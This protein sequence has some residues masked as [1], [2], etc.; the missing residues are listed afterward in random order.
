MGIK[1]ND[2]NIIYLHEDSNNLY[3]Q[4]YLEDTNI[5]KTEIKNTYFNLKIEQID[6][7][8][9]NN[10]AIIRKYTFIN[11]HDIPLDIKFLAHS[12]VKT[13]ENNYVSGKKL[14]NGLLQYA[15]DYN[16]AIISNELNFYNY[17]K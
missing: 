12:K 15:H 2:S 8:C 4:E 6:F 11:E 17:K 7:A 10:N 1:I 9:L 14:K 13:D 3:R 5:L 16:M